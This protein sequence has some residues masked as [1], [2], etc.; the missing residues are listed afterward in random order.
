MADDSFAALPDDCDLSEEAGQAITDWAKVAFIYLAATD[1]VVALLADT[2]SGRREMDQYHRE[3]KY[4]LRQG[5]PDADRETLRLSEP[6]KGKV[7]QTAD[8]KATMAARGKVIARITRLYNKLRDETFPR[9]DDDE[10]PFKKPIPK[11]PRSS[12]DD[13]SVAGTASLT[14]MTT[15]NR[16]RA[17]AAT[18]VPAWSQDE[19]VEDDNDLD[20][21]ADD[22][23]EPAAVAVQHQPAT[24]P[25]M[26]QLLAGVFNIVIDRSFTVMDPC[27]GDGVLVRSMVDLGINV[28][29][30]D[31]PTAFLTQPVPSEV[32]VVLTVPPS[33]RQHEFIAKLVPWMRGNEC[34]AFALLLPLDAV[35]TQP[36]HAATDGARFDLKFAVG[37]SGMAWYYF[38][39]GA[40]GHFDVINVL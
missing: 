19:G 16:T 28:I 20:D 10:T 24:P 23:D 36:F 30:S 1:R 11:S 29:A 3:V 32:C 33:S 7:G 9:M 14:T 40:E 6:I 37:N 5:L 8:E 31:D 15:A 27:A 22:D 39:N 25:E 21:D 34:H 17:S 38:F 26:V 35:T 12:L 13:A 4:Y 2:F 18:A